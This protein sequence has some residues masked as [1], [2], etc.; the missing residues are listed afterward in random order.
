MRCE[1]GIQ[2]QVTQC[3]CM[4]LLWRV[5]CETVGWAAWRGNI[6]LLVDQLCRQMVN[7]TNE[8]ILVG[9]HPRKEATH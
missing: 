2:V 5:S 6:S 7:K 9:L 1:E 8:I 3:L 4:H